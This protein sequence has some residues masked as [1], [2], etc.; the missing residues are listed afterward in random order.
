MAQTAESVIARNPVN[1][2]FIPADYTAPISTV[3]ISYDDDD[4]DSGAIGC[5]TKFANAH[6][7]GTGGALTQEGQAQFAESMVQQLVAKGH[8]AGKHYVIL[9]F[10]NFF[11]G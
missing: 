7:S 5:V 3:A 4:P 9:I 6:F 1:V 11:F 8:D 10:I 2:L